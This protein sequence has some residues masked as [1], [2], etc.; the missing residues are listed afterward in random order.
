MRV[1]SRQGSRV[2][3]ECLPACPLRHP[4]ITII[5]C[6]RDPRYHSAQRFQFLPPGNTVFSYS[7]IFSK[8]SLFD[9][10]SNLAALLAPITA[11]SCQSLLPLPACFLTLLVVACYPS[12]I[13]TGPTLW[14]HQH[15]HLQSRLTTRSETIA[16]I[17]TH[18]HIYVTYMFQYVI[19]AHVFSIVRIHSRPFC[20]E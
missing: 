8:N 5:R 9:V 1:H 11:P 12:S 13:K 10:V 6:P 20:L 4:G 19:Y 15:P 14:P 16:P 18:T 3:Q 7:F 17:F 2:N